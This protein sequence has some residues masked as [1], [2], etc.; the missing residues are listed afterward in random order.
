MYMKFFDTNKS[1]RIEKI[2]SLEFEYKI[3]KYDNGE[4]Q[5][6]L[7]QIKINSLIAIV[8]ADSAF[9]AVCAAVSADK[10]YFDLTQFQE[11]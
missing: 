6:V 11:G 7:P 10:N 4:I 9:N 3:S 5:A 8:K 1:I 2:Q